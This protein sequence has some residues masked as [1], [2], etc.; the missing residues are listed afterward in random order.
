MTEDRSI[1]PIASV[2][3]PRMATLAQWIGFEVEQWTAATMV[4]NLRICDVPEEHCE[5]VRA[6]RAHRLEITQRLH[7]S[8]E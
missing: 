1:V 6:L 3:V 4:R 5:A 7:G 8:A 2:V